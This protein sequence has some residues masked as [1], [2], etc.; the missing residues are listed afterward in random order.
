MDFKTG[1]IHGNSGSLIVAGTINGRA[2]DLTIDTGSDISI[3]RADVLSGESQEE[4]Q[5]VE[6]CLRTA[7]GEREPLHGISQLELGIGSR[8]LPK[9]LWVAGIHDQCI[10]G[11]DF[12][13]SHSFQV[14]LR[15]GML[16]VDEEEIPLRRSGAT[17]EPSCLKVVLKEGVTYTY[18]HC[19]RL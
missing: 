13:H 18:P 8:R 12:L 9:T 14:N 4:I 17:Q 2:C 10:L 7:T 16:I 6:G 5:P 11:L 19:L 15:D 3:V 1:T